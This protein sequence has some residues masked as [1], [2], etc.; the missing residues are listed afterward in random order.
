MMRAPD[1]SIHAES[2]EGIRRE[3]CGNQ[4][5]VGPVQQS[6]VKAMVLGQSQPVS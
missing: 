1:S 2:R 4:R 5:R 6:R 3:V